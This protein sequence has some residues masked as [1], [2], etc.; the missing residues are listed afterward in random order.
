[1]RR[2]TKTSCQ[3]VLIL[4]LTLNNMREYIAKKLLSL[5]EFSW[6]RLDYLSSPRVEISVKL[7]G[8]NKL[9]L[10]ADFD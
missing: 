6:R 2:E 8:T 5:L 1:M 10:Q 3:N 9:L 7:A 4:F